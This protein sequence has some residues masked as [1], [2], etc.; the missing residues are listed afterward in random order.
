MKISLEK[1]VS[2]NLRDVTKLMVEERQKEFIQENV[3]SIAA[4]AVSAYSHLFHHRA[5]CLNNSIVGFAQ[6]QFGEMGEW[7]ENECTIWH[8]MVDKEHQRKGIGRGAMK[9]LTNEIKAHNR[10]QLIDI[11]YHP[12]NEPAKKMYADSGFKETGFRDN[13]D[14]IAEMAV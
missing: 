4:A 2:E 11:Y 12:G 8:F 14:V 1:V 5:I 6:Y 10:C 3:L 13:G 7:D 9:I